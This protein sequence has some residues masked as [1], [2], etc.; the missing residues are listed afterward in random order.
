MRTLSDTFTIDPHA[1]WVAAHNAEATAVLEAYQADRPIRVP[2]MCGEWPGQH[3]FYATEVAL[4]YREYYTNPD[5]MLRVQLEAA[6]RRRELPIYDFPL[7]EAPERWPVSVDFWPVVTPGWFGCPLLYRR[8]AVIAHQ[9]LHLSKEECDALEMP[10][11]RSGGILETVG[12]FW[13]YL[14]ETYEDKFTFLGRPVGP[15]APGV[16]ITGLFSLALD[17]RGS[18]IMVDMYDDPEFAHRFLRKIGD[19]CD[20]LERAWAELTGNPLPP[21][22]ISD[23]GIDMLSVDMYEEFILPRVLEL[24]QRRGTE[25]PHCLHHCGRGAHLFPTMHKHYRLRRLNMLTYPMIDIAKV[26]RDLGE[27]IWIDAHIDDG[28]VNFGPP[29]RIHEA[30]KEFM[31]SGV[32]GKGRLALMSGDLLRGTNIE[33]Q[34]AL[35]AAVKEYGRY[36]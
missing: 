4:D 20:A 30:V 25:P 5:E 7:G 12:R 1:P 31:A 2:L 33:H 32:K 6:R 36:E 34:R 19:C 22:E 13:R 14:K 16:G 18:D 28:I 27:D 17:L 24:N 3:G 26:R 35:Y 29:E 23:H 8:D 9:P 21:F 11:P 10:D 15:I